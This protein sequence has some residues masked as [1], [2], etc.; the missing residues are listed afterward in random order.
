M[1]VE[2]FDHKGKNIEDT[3]M[4]GELVCTRAHPSMPVCFW[5]DKNDEKYHKAYFDTYPGVWRHADFIVKNPQTK[6]YIILGRRYVL[7]TLAAARHLQMYQRWRTQPERCPLRV[8]RD[9]HGP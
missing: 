6:G 9:L 2:I 1:A 3:G 4:P 7:L 5:G 8:G